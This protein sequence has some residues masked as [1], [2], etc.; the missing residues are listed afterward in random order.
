MAEHTFHVMRIY[1]EI[2]GAISS[3]TA[4]NILVH[5][6][7]EIASGDIP[8]PIKMNNPVLKEEIDRL[9]EDALE[10]MGLHQHQLSILEKTRIKICDLLE[11]WEF[12][13][14]E[15]S[16]GNHYAKPIVEQTSR[17]TRDMMAVLHEE[18]QNEISEYITKTHRQL[19]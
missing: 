7:G 16:M 12:G 5:D 9:E 3:Q 4:E 2:F 15:V 18:E 13:M 10:Q 19:A 14:V 11:M 17:A 1:L 6:M 8:F